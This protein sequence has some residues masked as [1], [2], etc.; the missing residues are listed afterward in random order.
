[1]KRLPLNKPD[2]PQSNRIISEEKRQQMFYHYKTKQSF[3]YVCDKAEVSY[4]TVQKYFVQDRWEERL[5]D[6][7]IKEDEKALKEVQEM[8]LSDVQLLD[9][10][11]RKVAKK[12]ITDDKMCFKTQDLEIL[13][14]L[15]L[16]VA[17]VT[18]EPTDPKNG[19]TTAIQNNIVMPQLLEG[20]FQSLHNSS[21]PLTSEERTIL[22]KIY[23]HARDRSKAQLPE[24]K[25][26][27]IEEG[28]KE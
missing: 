13:F 9:Q 5:L 7:T 26:V 12:I 25:K 27:V 10:V 15:K 22:Y 20:D 14:K 16:L 6:T 17:G 8:K 2:K 28:E 3:Q 21:L 24:A 11:I 23:N 18:G 1:M 19:P 4:P